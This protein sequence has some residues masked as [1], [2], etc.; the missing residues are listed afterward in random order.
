MIDCTTSTRTIKILLIALCSVSAA[1]AISSSIYYSMPIV[2]TETAVDVYHE[3]VT[4]SCL[5]IYIV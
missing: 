2:I 3:M 5:V 1:L 4:A